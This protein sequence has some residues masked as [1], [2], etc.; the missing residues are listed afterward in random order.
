MG[1]YLNGVYVEHLSVPHDEKDKI[2]RYLGSLKAESAVQHDR[3]D[4]A[5]KRAYR[6]AL[7][8]DDGDLAPLETTETLNE[9]LAALLLDMGKA[10]RLAVRLDDPR[11]KRI[12]DALAAMP[13]SGD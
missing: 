13:G 2:H 5:T 7:D 10:Y 8:C 1:A 12:V 4:A 3:I 9:A 11:G 6:T